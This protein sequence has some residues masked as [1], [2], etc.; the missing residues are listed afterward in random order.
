MKTLVLSMISIAATVAAMTACTSESDE[1]DNVVEAKVP[2]EL[3]AGV[4]E[5]STKAAIEQ[6]KGFDATVIASATQDNYSKLLWADKN[7]GDITVADGGAVSFTTDQYYPADGSTIYMVGIAPRPSETISAGKVDYTITGAEDIMLATEISGSKKEDVPTSK[8]LNFNHLLTQLKI[9]V[10]AENQDASDAWGTITS[11]QVLDA[12]T[13]LTLDINNKSIDAAT[14]PDKKAL[15]I[16]GFTTGM[17]IPTNTAGSAGYSMLLPQAS[18]VYQLLVK[19]SNNKTGVTIT[20]E[21]I[22]KLEASTAYTIK[23][24]FKSKNV[25][26]TATSG[27]WKSDTSGSASV[28]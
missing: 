23:L 10:V 26:V 3:K 27:E 18:S 4:M 7:A 12:A 11:I 9:D 20:P 19:T 24:T 28:E 5:I 13:V 2:I 17:T 14:A 22:T 25:E 1:I 6:G 8:E 16:Q 21:V 15:D